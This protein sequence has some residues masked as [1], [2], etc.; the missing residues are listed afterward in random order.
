[1]HKRPTSITLLINAVIALIARRNDSDV[2]LMDW[3]PCGGNLVQ[4]L[5]ELR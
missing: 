3:S 1:M 5:Q 2:G 4:W